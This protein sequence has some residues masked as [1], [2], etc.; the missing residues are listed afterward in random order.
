MARIK[1]EYEEKKRERDQ[2]IDDMKQQQ[3]I[4]DKKTTACLYLPD[5]PKN[6]PPRDRPPQ[7]PHKGPEPCEELKGGASIKMQPQP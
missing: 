6:S 1:F 5:S 4:N 7:V 2:I 3:V